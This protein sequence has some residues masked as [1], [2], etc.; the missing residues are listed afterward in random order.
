VHAADP[1]GLVVIT[2]MQPITV[3][4]T[5]AQDQLPQVLKAQ[6]A[7]SNLVVDAYNRDGTVRLATGELQ[8]ID[9]QIDPTTGM[10]RFKAVFA[11]QDLMLYPNQFVN[12]RLLV[13]TIKD[14]TLVAAAAI[15]HSPQTP[16]FVYVVTDNKTKDA[17]IVELRP[18][19]IGPIEGDTIAVT[20]GLAAGEEAVTDGVDKLQPGS[21]VAV[22]PPATRPG[23][24]T[25]P[26]TTSAPAGSA[27]R[28]AR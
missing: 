3:I 12:V 21:K 9:N 1:S 6:H 5:L 14:T 22:P 25:V 7:G 15:Q 13:D 4:F 18:V 24:T 20:D 27:T 10:V 19:T 17:K 16:N 23:A 2:Q 11:N 8:A 26:A 28:G